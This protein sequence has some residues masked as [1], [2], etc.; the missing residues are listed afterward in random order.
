MAESV[1]LRVF[2]QAG[3]TL[4]TKNTCKSAVRVWLRDIAVLYPSWQLGTCNRREDADLGDR[5]K[6]TGAKVKGQRSGFVWATSGALDGGGGPNV[7]YR[8]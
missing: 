3:V 7:A 8:F 5:N 1:W 4:R 2:K 6:V